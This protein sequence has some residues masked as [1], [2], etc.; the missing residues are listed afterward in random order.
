MFDR[1]ECTYTVIIIALV[2]ASDGFPIHRPHLKKKE[3]RFAIFFH[4]HNFFTKNKF[5]QNNKQH[6]LN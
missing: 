4:L 2:R 5:I 1:Q 6:S 3:L